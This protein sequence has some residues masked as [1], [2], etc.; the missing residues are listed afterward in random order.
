MCRIL[1]SSCGKN[2]AAVAMINWSRLVEGQK[3]G[4]KWQAHSKLVENSVLTDVAFDSLLSNYRRCSSTLTLIECTGQF[5]QISF[6]SF[7]V[8]YVWNL[9]LNFTPDAYEFPVFIVVAIHGDWCVSQ[10]WMRFRN[11]VSVHQILIFT[12][13][14]SWGDFYGVFHVMLL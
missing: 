9:N 2:A 5:N 10:Q 8:L 13:W 3:K 4:K 1:V 6:S 12:V 14:T 7:G 11:A